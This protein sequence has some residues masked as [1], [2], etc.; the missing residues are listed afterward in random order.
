LG[1]A[2]AATNRSA[3]SCT[4]ALDASVT[5]GGQRAIPSGFERDGDQRLRDLNEGAAAW[6]AIATIG[7]EVTLVG[8]I[9]YSVRLLRHNQVAKSQRYCW[10]DCRVR[11]V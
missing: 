2:A 7:S 4:A 11:R 8:G 10:P 9:V 6:C 3:R 1:V 5:H